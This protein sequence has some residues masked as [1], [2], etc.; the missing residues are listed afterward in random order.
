MRKL[1]FS[2][3]MLCAA[4]PVLGREVRGRVLDQ[5]AVPLEGVAVLA[6]PKTGT[7][8]GADG[9]FS[10]RVADG[11]VS[12]EFS[13]LGYQTVHQDVPAMND[14]VEVTLDTDDMT[15]DETVVIG[16]GT[17]KKVNLTGAVS[18]VTSKELA[19]R[20][21]NTLTHMLQGSVPGLY[22]KTY[23]GNPADE[24]SINIRGYASINNSSGSAL[25]LVD[26]VE[27]DLAK[28][29]PSDVESV[30]VIKDAS[31]S[32]IYGARAAYGVILVTT[33]SGTASRPVV[34]YNGHVGF[35]VP[36]TDTDYETRGY[37]SVYTLDLF[38]NAQKGHNYSNYTEADMAELYARRNDK[39]ENPDRPWI[40]TEER[41]G[42]L[43]YIY[44]CNTDWYHTLYTDFNPFTRHNVSVSGGD[45]KVKY[46]FSGGYEHKEGTFQVRPEKFNKYNLRSKL[47]VNVTPWLSLSDNM[48]F[49]NQDYDYPGNSSVD[50]TF[51]YSSV[52]AMA[53][54][55]PKNPDGTW[56]YQTIFSGNNVTNGCHIELGDD[57]KY[58]RRTKYSF[59]NTLELSLHP[60][61]GLDIRA[62]YSYKLNQS[63]YTS[64]WT[65]MEYSKYPGEIL[66]DTQGRFM[67]RLEETRNV[68]TYNAANLWATYGRTF[69][70]AHHV[71][72]VL[73]ANYEGHYY[74]NMYAYGDNL[75][76]PYVND[77]NTLLST[78]GSGEKSTGVGGGQGRY[79]L[80]GIFG[81][82]NYDYLE[83]YLFEL[84]FREDA[85]SKFPDGHRWGF[86][87]SV[88]GG[89]K[90]SEEPFWA[91]L[92]DV[93]SLNKLRLSYGTLGNQSIGEYYKFVRTVSLSSQNYLFGG[94]G[95]VTSATL[96]DPASTDI[97]WETTKHYNLGLDQ[98]F[99]ANRL[100]FTADL[101]IRDTEGMVVTGEVLPAVYGR[102]A[103]ERNAADLR[104]KGYEL[105]VTWKDTFG[106]LGKPFT[107]GITATL[108]DD[109]AKITKYQNPTRILNT[110][111]E[112]MTL[113]EIWGYRTDGFFATDEE[114]AAY[115]DYWNGGIDCDAVS[116][117]LAGGWKAGDVKFLDLDGNR[118]INKG[119]VTVDEP[120][121]WT[122]IGNSRP[123]YQYGLTLTA[124]WN[125]FDF[126]LFCQGIGKMDLWPQFDNTSFWGPYNREASY[127][128]KDF[129]DK[130][131]SEAHPDTYY[132]RPRGG[133][134]MQSGTYISTPND[135]FLL[136]MAYL[137]VK[138]LTLG[139]TLPQRFVDK[140]GLENVRVYFTGENLAYFC[141]LKDI[142]PY[143]DP[144][145]MIS[146]GTLGFRYP[147]QKPFVFG[148]DITF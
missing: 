31:S 40:L 84:S 7:L 41:G 12:L 45:Q 121:D 138:N 30:S 35:S 42:R 69:G 32:A 67:N 5:D 60:L 70:G 28:V 9:T 72:A 38:I 37:D 10:L 102:G 66:K 34:H 94:D 123:R 52:H 8:T 118:I 51:A 87:P 76:S 83:K 58:N 134:A 98:G 65:N 146:S 1:L 29:N 46:Y 100:L 108:A 36:T 86:F 11:P 25:V 13:C 22:V 81:R 115:T 80:E 82:V 135:K 56:V 85:S 91:L 88:S 33:K 116:G 140:V 16:Y 53:S 126:S 74:K 142:N 139:Y 145:Q 44:Y 14:Y 19:N 27:G 106:F 147:W 101:F 62:N 104:T 64:R 48:S 20:T 92:R 77:F 90:L 24:A 43:S 109:I 21:S 96:S 124:Q 17:A 125:G 143:I 130:C 128:Q 26:G 79:V 50:Y 137:R 2:L 49:Y 133:M 144:E 3:L 61:E 63:V 114:A 122:V 89:W 148:L 6:G 93:W 47:D 23:S 103:P 71:K 95:K 129:L 105:S 120:G 112:G 111:Y 4:L 18:T 99:F 110:Y 54:L 131:W 73:G 75:S 117:A 132:P 39:T 15:L 107:Y 59:A 127:I 141:A 57:T 55:P 113:G 119:S 136:D 97:T 68:S 78:S